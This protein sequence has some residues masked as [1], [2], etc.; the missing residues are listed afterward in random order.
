MRR[1]LDIMKLKDKKTKT[2][3]AIDSVVRDN[4]DVVETIPD[5]VDK[6]KEEMKFISS[7]I[8]AK[9]RAQKAFRAVAFEYGSPEK[10]Y[11]I[12]Q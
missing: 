7:D 5:F 9:Q 1:E 3:D 12:L 4:K 6:L 8:P 11:A 10:A 2:K